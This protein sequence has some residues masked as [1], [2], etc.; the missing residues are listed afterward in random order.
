MYIEAC[1]E[2]DGKL[3]CDFYIPG[4]GNGLDQIV[5]QLACQGVGRD[6]IVQVVSD[7]QVP[8]RFEV[9]GLQEKVGRV[10]QIR[11]VERIVRN[12]LGL[13]IFFGTGFGVEVPAQRGGKVGPGKTQAF[14]LVV[15]PEE[16]V[17]AVPVLVG[18]VE[19][20]RGAHV[21]VEAGSSIP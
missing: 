18:L 21:D 15:D 16:F 20:E 10:V 19:I 2:V 12:F 8:G 5:F 1:S 6:D 7:V 11:S 14:L 3:V 9:D 4:Q 17:V 13:G